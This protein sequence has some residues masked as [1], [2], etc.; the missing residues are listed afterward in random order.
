MSPEATGG[1]SQ[2]AVT[3][4][5]LVAPLVLFCVALL[6]RLLHLQQIRLNDPFFGIPAVDGRLYHAWAQQIAAGDLIGE[7]VL[8]LGPLYPYVLGL[9]YSI[10]GPNLFVIK[11]H[12]CILGVASCVLVWKLAA[13]MFDRRVLI[14]KRNCVF[15]NV[16]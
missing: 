1:S 3:P 16:R 10:A 7:G 9:V 2:G 11:L 5:R 15:G 13:D 4:P 8:I 6:I 12:Q 14:G